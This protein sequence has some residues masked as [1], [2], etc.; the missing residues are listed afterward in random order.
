M[1]FNSI[2]NNFSGYRRI[3]MVQSGLV[4]DVTVSHYRLSFHLVTAILIISIIFG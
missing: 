3:V 1:L 4:N 2:F